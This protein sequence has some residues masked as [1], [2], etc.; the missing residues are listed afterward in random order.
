MGRIEAALQGLVEALRA[1]D[2][3]ADLDA[4]K[5]KLPGV[6]VSVDRLLDWTLSGGGMI[7]ARLFVVVADR[8][9]RRVLEALDD[10][11]ALVFD[12]VDPMSDVE[13][14][15]LQLPNGGQ[16]RPALTFTHD[17]PA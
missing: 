5:V 12:V 8:D 9:D 4:A 11:C 17:I 15:N 16:P 1:A 3:Q 10:I 13:T 2:V 6:W 7:R 14:T